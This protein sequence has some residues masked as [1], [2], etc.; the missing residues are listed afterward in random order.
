MS[1]RSEKS[2]LEYLEEAD[3]KVWYMRSHPC[4]NKEIEEKRKEA[5]KKIEEKYPEVLEGFDDWECGYWN[6][7]LG[8][9]RWVLGEE[10]DFLD[11]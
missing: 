2:I 7:V 8:A 6:G 10:K 1:R 11:T 9:L 3:H 5:V 4:E